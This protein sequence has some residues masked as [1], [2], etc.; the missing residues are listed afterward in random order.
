MDEAENAVIPACPVTGFLEFKTQVLIDL[1]AY[2]NNTPR[3]FLYDLEYDPLIAFIISVIDR[4][5]N[6][7]PID[8]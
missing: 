2:R 6:H 7:V 4:I 5:M 1:L 3:F 8:A